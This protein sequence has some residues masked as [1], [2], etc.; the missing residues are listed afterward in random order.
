MDLRRIVDTCVKLGFSRMVFCEILFDFLLNVRFNIVKLQDIRR[1]PCGGGGCIDSTRLSHKHAARS[2]SAE[3]L[4]GEPQSTPGQPR[5]DEGVRS[6]TTRR[7]GGKG[8]ESEKRG[9]RKIKND[10]FRIKGNK[11]GG[12]SQVWA[13]KRT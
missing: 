3:P 10:K 8:I 6:K 12:A 5:Q 9:R 4:V 11:I 13:K 2:Y 1:K 7:L